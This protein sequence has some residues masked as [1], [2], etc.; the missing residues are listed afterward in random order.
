VK[1]RLFATLV[2]SLLGSASLTSADTLSSVYTPIST[3]TISST[4][5]TYFY[6]TW[7]C[8]KYDH[9][10]ATSTDLASTAYR[11][12][13]IL[14]TGYQEADR[15]AFWTDFDTIIDKMSN[16]GSVWSTVK[17]D[18]LIWCGYF[19]GGGP[20][21]ASDAMF[22]A[23]VLPHPVR[24]YALSLSNNAVYS[25][26]AYMKTYYTPYLRPMGALVIF[27]DFQTDI[28]ANAAP[29]SFVNKSYGVAKM[30]RDDLHSGYIATHEL[31]HAALNF[32]DEYVET[33]LENINIRS[34]DVA[35]PLLLFD[36]TWSGFWAAFD[37]LIGNYDY[38]ISE[39]FANNGNENIALST[40]PST[41]SS[42][43]SAPVQ[44]QDEG[45]FFVGRGTRHQDGLNLMNGNHVMRTPNDGFGYS[46]TGIQWTSI[47]N[48]FG[49]GAYRANDRLRNAGPLNDWFGQWGSE[50]TVMMFDGDKRHQFHKTQQ[51]RVQVAWQERH[52]ETCWQW[53]FIP[54]PCY[55]DE[56][57]YAEKTIYPT[58]RSINLESSS[59][60]GLANFAQGL[61]CGVGVTEI[62]K[63]D[64]SMFQLCEKP[65]SDVLGAFIPSF[66]FYT[67]YDL[68]K[69]PASQWLT[70]YWWCFRTWNGTAWSG[71][72]G[73]SS[74]YR[75][76]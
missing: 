37:D 53:G 8:S 66:R 11:H 46:H 40:V 52:W 2:A 12:L 43:I 44:M 13:V 64:G 38:N 65:L 39:I 42:P 72:T 7:K 41:V 10:A 57:K 9:S 33:G 73:W 20:I 70:T 36:W 50:T 30:N 5:L 6:P 62:P 34:L 56:W 14:S 51:Y 25:K 31:G 23:K 67:P 63:P 71:W 48:A 35:T 55:W 49:S 27:N 60:Y 76:L 61:L 58:T 24:A 17:R 69:V 59:L 19:T 15:G 47:E 3:T 28:T 16:S 68:A 26:V 54:Y 32:L 1:K 18:R 22:G 4:W 45:G 29:P 74:F 21:G 75:Y